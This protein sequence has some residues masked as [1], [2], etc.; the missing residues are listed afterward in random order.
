MFGVFLERNLFHHIPDADVIYEERTGRERERKVENGNQ[1]QIQLQMQR[2]H[3]DRQK[4]EERKS[5]E[6]MSMQGA[7]SIENV[8]RVEIHEYKQKRKYKYK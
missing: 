3:L 1:I 2:V 7:P 8:E 5:K 4:S 6:V